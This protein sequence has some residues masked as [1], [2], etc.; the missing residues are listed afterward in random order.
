M[1]DTS[2]AD[3]ASKSIK[4]NNG[5]QGSH[6]VY[7][8]LPT[9]TLAAECKA[10]GVLIRGFL[11]KDLPQVRALFKSG[12]QTYSDPMPPH[13]VL[14]AFWVDYYEGALAKDL[15]DA[16]AV[17]RTYAQTGG[18]FWV[19]E[20]TE[21]VAGA[22]VG[23]IVGIVAMEKL[24]EAGKVTGELRRMS[25]AP[26]M[27]GKGV[28]KKLVRAVEDFAANNGYDQLVLTTGSIMTPAMHLYIKAGWELFREGYHPA[29]VR[30]QLK[31]AG[32]VDIYE[33]AFRKPVT[34]NQGRWRWAPHA[35]T[36]MVPANPYATDAA[37]GT[38]TVIR[39]VG[40]AAVVVAVAAIA[41]LR[42]GN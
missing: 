9:S 39:S 26:S 11:P 2:V 10:E 21:A 24:S 17:A 13:S 30:A 27:Q 32:D 8:N 28:G 7:F 3:T 14:K 36:R 25:V 19:V 34:S 22:S 33:A 31:A 35:D 12:M 40:L 38:T 41:W 23:D 18:Y 16:D 29:D 5:I 42:V 37:A 20:L 4:D 15:A 6:D 1:A